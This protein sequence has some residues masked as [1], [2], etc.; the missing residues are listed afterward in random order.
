MMMIVYIFLSATNTTQ[1]WTHGKVAISVPQ[2]PPYVV[3]T[4]DKFQIHDTF[5]INMIGHIVFDAE[6]SGQ[7]ESV[8]KMGLSI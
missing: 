6:K 4:L 2:I 1:E 8:T 7:S 5:G 3:L